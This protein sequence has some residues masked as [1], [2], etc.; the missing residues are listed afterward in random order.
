VNIEEE[1]IKNKNM[2]KM[3]GLKIKAV[4]NLL[5]KE[6]IITHEEIEGEVNNL[7]NQKNE[8]SSEE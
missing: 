4:I 2:N 6:G 7:I 3:N 8:E 5:S 1:T